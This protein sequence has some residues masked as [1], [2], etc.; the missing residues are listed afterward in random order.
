MLILL[1][2]AAYEACYDI[3]DWDS[4]SSFYYWKNCF[5][6]NRPSKKHLFYA[7]WL[8]CEDITSLNGCGVVLFMAISAIVKWTIY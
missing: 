4:V 6:Y 3:L 2:E 1:P 8:A 5:R 7:C